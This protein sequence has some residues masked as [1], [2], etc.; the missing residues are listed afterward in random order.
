[1]SGSAPATPPED[2]GDV[3]Q[4]VW[5]GTLGPRTD[6]SRMELRPDELV[7]LM[8]LARLADDVERIRTE[9][10]GAPLT[11]P[12]S[13]GQQVANPLR[14]ELHRSTQRMEALQ[15]TLALPDDEGGASPSWA[16]RNLARARWSA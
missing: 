14:T 12:G 6:G 7:L 9:L 3:G 13:K 10:V 1:M 2:L 4:R 15:K 8:E 16:G 11:V 5:N